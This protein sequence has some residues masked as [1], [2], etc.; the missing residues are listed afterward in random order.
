[1]GFLRFLPAF[2]DSNG[3][4]PQHRGPADVERIDLAGCP[5]EPVGPP[6]VVEDFQPSLWQFRRYSFESELSGVDELS[7]DVGSGVS[8]D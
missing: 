1:M 6:E 7:S 8:C 2:V 5:A 4:M 3:R